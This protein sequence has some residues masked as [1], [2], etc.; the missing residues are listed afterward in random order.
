MGSRSTPH[1]QGCVAAAGWAYFSLGALRHL[2]KGPKEI[3]WLS[4]GS[5]G[6]H[7]TAHFLQVGSVYVCVL[8]GE[9]GA[10]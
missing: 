10:G 1:F 7:H 6:Y 8:W 2:K 5:P 3:R 9:G 4:P